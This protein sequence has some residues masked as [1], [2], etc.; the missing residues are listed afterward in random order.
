MVTTNSLH[1]VPLPILFSLA[2]PLYYLPQ[3]VMD[4]V[5]G[6]R[7]ARWASQVAKIVSGNPGKLSSVD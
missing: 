1:H 6:L 7:E 2:G 5:M 4:A 3:Q